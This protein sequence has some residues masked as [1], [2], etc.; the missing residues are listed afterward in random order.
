MVQNTSEGRKQTWRQQT[1]TVAV[2]VKLY[3][4][5]KDLEAVILKIMAKENR[6]IT[7]KT[8]VSKRKRQKRNNVQ[9]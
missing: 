8:D 4:Y 9:I 2:L 1:E 7:I 6:L 5:D 3:K